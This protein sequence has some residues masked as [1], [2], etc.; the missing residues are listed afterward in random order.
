MEEKGGMIELRS[1]GIVRKVDQLGRIVI[2]KELRRTLA[3]EEKD[4]LEFFVN[5]DQIILKKYQY[6]KTCMITGKVSED[7]IVL[8]NGKVALSREGMEILSEEL[9][10]IDVHV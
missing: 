3:I 1:T 2:P 8:G 9:R 5:E 4:L 6:Y 7:N 10:K